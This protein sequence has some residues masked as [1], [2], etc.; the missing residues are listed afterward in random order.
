MSSDIREIDKLNWRQ[1]SESF[2]DATQIKP[3]E[4]NTLATRTGFYSEYLWRV[5]MG[6]VHVEVPKTWSIDYVRRA[7]FLGILRDALARCSYTRCL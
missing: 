7:L 6:S 1:W 4:V 5:F 2:K 3:K